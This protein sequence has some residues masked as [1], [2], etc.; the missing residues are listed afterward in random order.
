MS[1]QVNPGPGMFGGPG[2]MSWMSPGPL[3]SA[4]PEKRKLMSYELHQSESQPEVPREPRGS[5][6]RFR[7]KHQMKPYAR[8]PGSDGRKAL[9]DIDKNST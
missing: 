5:T 2:A 1:Q 9:S 4:D 8:N 3:H 7:A 6:N